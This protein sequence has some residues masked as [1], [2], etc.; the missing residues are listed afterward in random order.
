[1]RHSRPAYPQRQKK[2]DGAKQLADDGYQVATKRG[3][4]AAERP[5]ENGIVELDWGVGIH[6]DTLSTKTARKGRRKRAA[7]Y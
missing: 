5:D 3:R 6:R 2:G 1:M 4:Q 7:L